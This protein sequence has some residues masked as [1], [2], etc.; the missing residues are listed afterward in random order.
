MKM[1]NMGSNPMNVQP[2]YR[3]MEK[4]KPI[5]TGR[6]VKS[7]NPIR[8]ISCDKCHKINGTLVHNILPKKGYV[9]QSCL[10]QELKTN[11]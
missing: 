5:K 3:D 10:N 7:P 9:H 11:D 2:F 6:N 1:K 4:T 8:F